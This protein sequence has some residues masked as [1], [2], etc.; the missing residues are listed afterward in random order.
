MNKFILAAFVA[1]IV[2][3]VLYAAHVYL[4]TKEYDVSITIDDQEYI[5]RNGE[6]ENCINAGNCPLAE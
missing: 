3:S 5:T 1:L 6:I 4:N 2:S